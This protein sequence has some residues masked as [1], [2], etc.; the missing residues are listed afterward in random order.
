M[1][2]S[3]APGF[4]R[5]IALRYVS[6]GRRS[7]L[8]SFM[9][10][11]AIFGLALGISLLITVLSVMNGFDREVRE[12]ILGI[13]P[14]LVLRTSESLDEQEW[15][16]LEAQM[17]AH[18]QVLA[19]APVIE[20]AG[21]VAT[22]GFS[23]GVLINGIEVSREAA[24]SRIDRFMEAGSLEALATTRW[25]VVLG[26]TLARA[27]AVEVG[28]RVD[29][30]SLNVSLNP[31]TPLANFRGFE[32]VGIYRVGTQELDAELVLMNAAAARSL[33][34]LRT[35]YTALRVKLQDVLAA[36]TVRRSLL[37]E[38]PTHV[39]LESWT[40]NFGS[41]YDNILF[42]RSI[43][44]LMLWLLI[45]VAAFNL[46]VSLIMVVR[47]KRG[48]IAILRTLGASPATINRIF[49]WQ[50][51]MVG[52]IGTLIGMVLG[53]LGSLWVGD[54]ARL[55]E[56]AFQI[57]L[58]SADV[59]PLDFLPSELRL[60]DLLWVSAGV[61]LLSLAATVYP[62]RR[63]AAVLPAEALRLD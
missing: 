63:A 1:S 35:P 7:Q 22:A 25:G 46:V 37:S 44:G 62:A 28:D 24:I 18:P 61:M 23:Q 41:I 19:T 13:I 59:Y 48:D 38:V 9:S 55:I 42:S 57:Q 15:Q 54:L 6:V 58:L 17:L 21:V 47:D 14:H 20:Q 34:R 50:G 26:A 30:F 29:V 27:L 11:L 40:L 12:N 31:L 60:S 8:V 33:W 43:V 53:I 36:D 49:L 4:A 3:D 51:C 10:A 39:T 5:Y 52:L 56:T 2:H 45:A 32:V 16:A